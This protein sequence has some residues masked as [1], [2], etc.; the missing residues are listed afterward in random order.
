MAIALEELEDRRKDAMR[1]RDAHWPLLEECYRYAMPYRKGITQTGPSQKRTNEI[2][3][4]QAIISTFRRAGKMA[5]NISPP[6]QIAFD[7]TPGALVNAIATLEEK[8]DLKRQLEQVRAVTGAHF[9]TGE[10]D[11]ALTEIC[12]DLQAGT[13]CMLID[14]HKSKLRKVAR[15]TS[16][17]IEETYLYSNGYGPVT[18]V[19]WP[20][21]WKLRDVKA[22]WPDSDLGPDLEK[23]LTSAPATEFDVNCDTVY[24]D[25][26]EMWFKCE[27]IRDPQAG[28]GKYGRK[29]SEDYSR[30]A[31]WLTPRYNRVP[32]ETYG[33]GQLML[34]MPKVKALNV[35]MKLNLQAIAI[36]TLG[37]YTAIDDGVFNPDNAPI[38]P[39]AFLKVARNGGALGPSIA[40]FP[41]PRID[42]TQIIFKDMRMD[43]KAGMNDS[44]LPPDAAAVRSAYEIME[45]LKQLASDDEAAWGRL[46]M[47]I[48]VPAVSRVT[49][50]AYDFQ[51]L[52]FIPN[53]DRLLVDMAVSSPLAMAAAA[54]RMTRLLKWVEIVVALVAQ[55]AGLRR[56]VNIEELIM[57]IATILSVDS[58]FQT[59]AEEREKID[60]QEAA[61]AA[62]AMAATAAQQPEAAAQAVEVGSAPVRL[63][64]VA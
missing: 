33:R 2:F 46:V 26:R 42:M 21:K 48:W 5:R 58:R 41:D 49:E 25:K 32:G 9:L 6:G 17:A 18:A 27:S 36:A 12:I 50:I 64:F 52:P 34:V 31:P 62:A 35:G 19:H 54:E 13:G 38:A 51:Q 22:E 60:E 56:F 16:V 44:A 15:F 3:D 14:K 45:R 59:T 43:I 23:L 30:T 1:I 28:D 11:T 24:D 55:M 61:V 47:E 20:R 57:E 8:E 40:R 10:W 7:L 4:E 63:G 37:V 29:L 53:I 39:G